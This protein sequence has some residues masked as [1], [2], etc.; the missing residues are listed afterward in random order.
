MQFLQTRSGRYIQT[1]H[2][3][4]LSIEDSKIVAKG[5]KIEVYKLVAYLPHPLTP[6]VIGIYESEERAY[7]ILDELV[8]KLTFQEEKIIRVPTEY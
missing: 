4:V 3:I 1:H 8:E 2:I 7:E 5:K 6:A